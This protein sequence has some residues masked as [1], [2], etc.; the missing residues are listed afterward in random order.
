LDLPIYPA[1]GI[2]ADRSPLLTVD[3]PRESNCRPDSRACL[4]RRAYTH[5]STEYEQRRAKRREEKSIIDGYAEAAVATFVCWRH[6]WQ[7]REGLWFSTARIKRCCRI[8]SSPDDHHL[9]QPPP[10]LL[11]NLIFNMGNRPQII[12][13]PHFSAMQ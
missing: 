11:H 13:K 8:P 2:H 9:P 5:A 6:V 1:F 7:I 12:I 10:P 4:D 3:K